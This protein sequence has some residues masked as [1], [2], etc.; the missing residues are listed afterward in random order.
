[1]ENRI[2]WEPWGGVLRSSER[3]FKPMVQGSNPCAGTNE[4]S[5]TQKSVHRLS[6]SRVPTQIR[7]LR[8]GPVKD[9]LTLTAASCT[10]GWAD[11]EHCQRTD[12]LGLR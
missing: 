6:A 7:D 12:A 11:W 1:V 4:F 5:C 8:L 9:D 3:A 10:T 2:R